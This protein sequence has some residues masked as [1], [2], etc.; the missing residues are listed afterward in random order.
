MGNARNIAFWLVLFLLILALFN[1]FSGS[2]N[3]LQSRAVPYSEFV[4]AVDSGG[5]SQVTLDGETVRYRG[6]DGQ[7]YATIKPE[8]AEITQRLIDAGIPVKAE[9]QQQSG[10]PAADWCVDLFHEPHA[11]R[12]Q[13]RCDG[14]W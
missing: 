12:R 9:S 14:L 6:S 8:D 11:G 1:L 7:D 3:T 2:G 5:V 13:R 4:A 10:F